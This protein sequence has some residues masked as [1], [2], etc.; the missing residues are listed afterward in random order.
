MAKRT[1]TRA[2]SEAV[3]L[4]P[5]EFPVEGGHDYMLRSIPKATWGQ[6]QRRA[7]AEGGRSV[8][9]VLLRLTAAYAERG[10]AVFGGWPADEA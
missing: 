1:R 4:K 8:R 2:K 10:A 5:G 9:A 3:Y 6:V 7:K